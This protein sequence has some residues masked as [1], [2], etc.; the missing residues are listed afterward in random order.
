MTDYAQAA[1][2]RTGGNGRLNSFFS[3]VT[4]AL[5][6]S[7]IAISH[8][9]KT[10]TLLS[11]KKLGTILFFV[12]VA[13]FVLAGLKITLAQ[14]APRGT[15]NRT[16]STNADVLT[17]PIN[18][19]FSFVIYDKDKNLADPIKYTVSDAQLTKQIII[20]GQKATAVD[21]RKFLIFN[22]KLVNDFNQSL[23]LNSRNYIRVQAKGSPDKLAPEIHND[24]VEVQPLSTKLT[25]LGLP[26]NE[27]DR[28]FTIYVGELN[29]EKEAIPVKF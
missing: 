22:L 11:K 29:G 17:A 26:V 25:R 18:H 7:S 5:K 12:I 8:K 28:E 9:Y 2:R 21:G 19:E 13:I 14:S 24:T 23:F 10:R 6:N 4:A 20:K 16:S 3:T 1:S 15:N 27:T